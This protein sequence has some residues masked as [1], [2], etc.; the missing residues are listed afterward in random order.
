V[1]DGG[2]V[3]VAN[4]L[5]VNR[6]GR[7]AG[8]GRIQGSVVNYG[9]IAPGNSV[10]T[11]HIDGDYVQLD[12]GELLIEIAAGDNFDTLHV[13]GNIETGGAKLHVSLLGGYSPEE[14]ATFDILDWTGTGVGMFSEIELPR[15]SRG[16]GWNT[17]QLETSGVLSVAPAYFQS[18]DFITHSQ[19]S[20]GTP[21]EQGGM[22]LQGH[23]DSVYASTAGQ[24]EI[25]VP[26][27][28]PAGFSIIFTSSGAALAYQPSTGP[29]APLGADLVDPASSESGIFGGEVLGLRFNVDFSD[30]GHTLG[31]MSIPFGDLVIHSYAEI[32][33]VNGLTVRE[34]LAQANILLGSG[35]VGYGITEAN[36][37]VSDLN[38]SFSGGLEL[39][40]F[41]QDHLRIAGDFNKD[42]VV[43]GAD[44]LVWQRGLGG[45]FDADDLVEW[46]GNFGFPGSLSAGLS[47]AVPEPAGAA[48]IMTVFSLAAGRTRCWAARAASRPGWH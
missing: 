9:R 32:P 29:P 25:G 21:M 24:I 37:L 10:G 6:S 38:Y 18:G 19:V 30:A 1:S 31:A 8:N 17:S 43:D 22:V 3:S 5:N 2:V 12:D 7:L 14:G 15:L 41:A 47:R 42:Y 48:V 28:G 44:F 46:R 26:I 39:L 45:E 23:Y 20:W 35:S 16:L 13:E 4:A 34:V 36:Q 27:P 11:L 40:Q 33:Q